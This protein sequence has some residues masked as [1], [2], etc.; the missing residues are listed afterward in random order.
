MEKKRKLKELYEESLKRQDDYRQDFRSERL[1]ARLKAKVREAQKV[2]QNLDAQDAENRRVD[3]ESNVF[4]RGLDRERENEQNENRFKRR[5]MYEPSTNTLGES[6]DEEYDKTVP[7]LENEDT[8]LDEF[9]SLPLENQ[10]EMI[11]YYMRGKH[12]YCLWYST[13]PPC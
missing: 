10:L 4:W 5:M 7:P 13:A 12:F 6:D 2:C 3:V 8:E 9:E 11:L 1:E